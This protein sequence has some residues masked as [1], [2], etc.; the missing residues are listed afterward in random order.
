MYRFGFVGAGNM[1][2][3]LIQGMLK[4]GMMASQM[5][6]YDPDASKMEQ[7]RAIGVATAVDAAS[8]APQCEVLVIAVKPRFMQG[9]I[10]GLQKSAVNNVLSIVLGWTQDML[11]QGFPNAMGV[12]HC[13]P[14]T[15]AAVG[16]G[17]FVFNDN[18]SFSTEA[19]AKL[20]ED[21]SLCGK[22]LQVPEYLFDAVT[23]ISGSGPAYVYMFI[24]ALADGGVR[25]GLP[26]DTA[27]TLAA[28]TVLGA[29]KMVL[30]TGMH[31]GALKDAVSSPGGS[32]I[33]A[34]YSLEESGFRAA[35]LK[36]V[37]ACASKAAKMGK[38]E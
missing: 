17:V 15:P 2:G 18:H 26:R 21:F 16:E 34:V 12:A 8:M 13:M 31:P 33:E 11:A 7:L 9:V 10:D 1:A 19:F 35:I 38:T 32:T 23:S 3:A 25:Q 4:G 37:D 6:A 22:V 14:N 30:D 27:Y 5:I 36:A 29:S 28:Q 20:S 24:E